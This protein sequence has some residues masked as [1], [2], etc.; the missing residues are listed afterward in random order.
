MGCGYYQ[1]RTF[2]SCARRNT[3]CLNKKQYGNFI[4]KYQFYHHIFLFFNEMALL[5][6]YD[7]HYLCALDLKQIL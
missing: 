3:I 1:Q 4:N 5:K 7:P 6:I 2:A